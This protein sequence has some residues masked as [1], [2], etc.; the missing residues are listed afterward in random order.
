[1]QRL[2]AALRRLFRLADGDD[3]GGPLWRLFSDVRPLK[4]ITA[5]DFRG[6]G[7]RGCGFFNV[8]HPLPVQAN[9]QALRDLGANHA[10]VWLVAEWT[11]SAYVLPGGQLARM[12]TGLGWLQRAGLHAVVCMGI[13]AEQE[14][15]DAQRR[16]AFAALW[17]SL[18]RRWRRRTVVAAFDL[19]NE[20]DPVRTADNH[21]WRVQQVHAAYTAA[22][23]AIR[24][25][26]PNRV[27]VYQCLQGYPP[28]FADMPPLPFPNSVPSLHSYLPHELTHQNTAAWNAG[29]WRDAEVQAYGPQQR[30]ALLDSLRGAHQ[31]LQHHGLPL[32]VGEFSCVN[33]AAGAP[34]YIADSLAEFRQAGWSWSYHDWR[35]WPGWDA[36]AVPHGRGQFTRRSDAPIVTLLRAAM[37]R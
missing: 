27:L 26:D 24:A 33:W 23:Q 7:M 18:A 1:M 34:Q 15:W 14:P 20:P 6:E 2:R 10:R 3:F 5:H 35:A 30:A 37:L 4:R 16:A 17:G 13:P 19:L 25:A 29:T 11:G 28:W 21:A 9:V 32:Y 36:E 22:A 12:E 31:W 8:K